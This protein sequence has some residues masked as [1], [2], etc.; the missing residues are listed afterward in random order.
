MEDG[1]HGVQDIANGLPDSYDDY[2]FAN[3]TAF[4][5]LLEEWVYTD[6]DLQ[7]LLSVL[8]QEQANCHFCGE[9]LEERYWIET[10]EAEYHDDADFR[11]QY[12]LEVYC[13]DHEENTE[14][15]YSTSEFVIR[16][17]ED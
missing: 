15:Q 10:E 11:R 9:T 14:F 13:P 3:A 8:E 4:V 17:E 6:E 1:W 12:N 7:E 2:E 5:N 16:D